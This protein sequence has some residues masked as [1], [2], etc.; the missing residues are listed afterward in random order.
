MFDLECPHCAGLLLNSEGS[1]SWN[2]HETSPSEATC[3]D[4]GKVS[5]VPKRVPGDLIILEPETETSV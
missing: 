4:C 5:K 3:G 1:M 2:I